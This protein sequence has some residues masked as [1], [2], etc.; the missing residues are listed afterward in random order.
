MATVDAPISRRAATEADIP[1]LLELRRITMSDH[2]RASGITPS[3]EE[4]VRRV[5][6]R[7]ECAE[8]IL[9]NDER[10]GL[11]K[12][13]RDGLEWE[14]AQIQLV[15]GAQRSGIGTRLL[16]EVV[17]EARAAGAS[18]RLEVLKANPAR[19][20]YRRLGFTVISETDHSYEMRL[21]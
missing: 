15:P 3:Q 12:V 14:I 2:Q 17:K 10:I 5:H 21:S 20:L 11:L 19:S 13:A 4:R 7:F 1:F 16:T 6:A 9:R 8:I 18:L